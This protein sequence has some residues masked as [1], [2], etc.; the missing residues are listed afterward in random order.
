MG[1]A[2]DLE[3]RSNI[4]SISS[5][6]IDDTLKSAFEGELLPVRG[7]SAKERQRRISLAMIHGFREEGRKGNRVS[8]P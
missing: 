2:S 5:A 3:H 6:E 1:S 4:G 7:T 8:Y